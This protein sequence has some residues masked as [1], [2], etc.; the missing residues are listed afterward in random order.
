MCAFKGSC[1]WAHYIRVLRVQH[2]SNAWICQKIFS[3]NAGCEPMYRKQEVGIA[4]DGKAGSRWDMLGSKKTFVT[5][6]SVCPHSQS[7]SLCE[8]S[9]YWR[10]SGYSWQST[11]YF[12]DAHACYVIQPREWFAAGK[13]WSMMEWFRVCASLIPEGD[14]PG[15]I[16]H[17]GVPCH[18]E[19]LW[20]Q[21]CHFERCSVLMEE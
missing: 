12:W 21:F 15:Y 5:V 3:E 11:F 19:T 14:T 17:I 16:M 18:K 6:L 7:T 13:F 2:F 1:T 20:F 10:P 8:A 4:P 9:V